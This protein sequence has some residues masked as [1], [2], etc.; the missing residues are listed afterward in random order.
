L[1]WFKYFASEQILLSLREHNIPYDVI[2]YVYDMV[3]NKFGYS[4]EE[5]VDEK[6]GSSNIDLIEDD[7]FRILILLSSSGYE[8]NRSTVDRI[9]N[10]GE[11][12]RAFYIIMLLANRNPNYADIVD[13]I[14][15]Y[16]SLKNSIVDLSRYF[17]QNF[18]Q[19]DS[20]FFKVEMNCI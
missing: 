17:Y 12:E 5:S 1:S 7:I 20:T 16:T 9:V 18:L 19:E 3:R 14:L 6:S 2:D 8:I 15:M 11:V 13:R 10:M 4:H